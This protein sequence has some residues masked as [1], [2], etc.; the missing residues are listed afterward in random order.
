VANKTVAL[1]DV[2]TVSEAAY[3]G[4]NL[5]VKAASSDSGAQLT[6]VGY[7]ALA[8]GAASFADVDAPPNVIT[9]RSSE[10]GSVTVPLTTSG[11]FTEPDLPVAVATVTPTRPMANQTVTLDASGSLDATKYEWVSDRRITPTSGLNEPKLTFSAP[12]GLYEFGLVVSDDGGRRSKV[13]TVPVRVTVAET[14]VARA[15]AAQTVLR[16]SNVT[17]D[18]SLSIGAETYSWEQIPNVEG[19]TFTPVTLSG[20]NTP[21]P[22]FT[23]PLN[24]LPVQPGTNSSYT[25]LAPTPL[26][27]QLTVTGNGQTSTA[28]T[29]VR[30]QAE[31]LAVTQARYRTRGEWRLQGTSD[32]KAGQRVAIVVGSRI[33]ATGLPTLASARGPVIGYATV[34]ALGAWQYTGA[35]PDPRTSGATSVTAVSTLGGQGVLSIEV[36]T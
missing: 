30:P 22:T 17:L 7:G 33:G 36:T 32:L 15:G 27:F 23:L 25:A 26:R 16:G 9:V 21:K 20:A 4:T 28:E 31:A 11:P 24:P 29:V 14:A 3:D 10:G 34:D 35:G 12:A 1:S 2:V 5:S 13:L 8:D 18:G 19:Q 6:V